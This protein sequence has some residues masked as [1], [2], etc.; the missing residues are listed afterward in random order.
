MAA[1]LSPLWISL[2]SVL[3][4]TAITFFLG[5]AAGRWL[6]GYHGKLRSFLDG[7]FVLPLV[8]P[9][10]V[11][12]LG[13]LLLFGVHGPMGKLLQLCG[14][15]VVFT[16]TATVIAAVVVSFPLMY[17]AARG[18]FEQVEANIEN[19]ART[20]GASEW[21]VFRSV[22]LPLAWPGVAAGLI[23]AFAR[24]LGEFGAT[25]MLAGYIPGR[26]GTIPMA[27][28]FAV[29]AG[30][31]N[32]A[33]ILVLIV[34]AVS[35]GSLAALAFWKGRAAESRFGIRGS[36]FEVEA[37]NCSSGHGC[38][39]NGAAS[40]SAAVREASEPT[41]WSSC[42]RNG[43]AS[44]CA[45]SNSGKG[46]R[47]GPE[48]EVAIRKSYP[49]FSLDVAFAVN[50]EILAIVGPSGSGKTMTLLCIA[51][52]IRPDA[53]YIRL[54]GR[55]LWDAATGLHLPPQQRKV[56][57]VF[58]NYALFPH[59][60]VSDNIALGIRH[61]PRPEIEER[62]YLLLDRMHIR[63][64]G[65]RYPG[66]LSGGQ[67]QRVAVA[68]ALAPEPEVLL[69][70]EPFAALDAQ[71][72]AR[73]EDELLALQDFYRGTVLFVTHDLAEGYK[74][75]SRIAVYESGRIL[76]C[77]S[78]Q[79]VIE[80][81]ASRAL[82]RLTGVR[83]LVSGHVDEIRGADA[84]VVAPVLGG[85]IRV[86]LKDGA[87]ASLS[88]GQQ[89]TVG[90]RPEYV[91]VAAGTPGGHPGRRA[92]PY[93]YPLTGTHPADG[94]R[95]PGVARGGGD[96]PPG[97]RPPDE[98]LLPGTVEQAVEGVAGIGYR[99]RLNGHAADGH[100]LEATISKADAPLIP[101]GKPCSVYLPPERLCLIRE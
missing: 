3:T 53:G 60:T 44:N 14:A 33:L 7:I 38:R 47:T 39:R 70:D 54:N 85:R 15:S 56:G 101:S 82:A 80:A 48:L 96:G 99:I 13:L 79:K 65:H 40:D 1:Y 93:G 75:S 59:L 83:N 37:D 49:E 90:I 19:A 51:G 98:N 72:R 55:A 78:K 94:A 32:Q 8:L 58:Q 35:F 66:Q 9:P 86:A 95:P 71:V 41:G 73:L 76:Q 43:A 23:L 74:L 89:V 62:V 22:T 20:L 42:R 31:M 63:G 52:L 30:D 84:W 68:R 6:A 97:E 18:A 91:R 16:W 88:V 25:L 5:I 36:G 27:I 57:F 87:S 11:V 34:L 21:R 81:P 24:A 100:Y 61:L 64:L 92:H 2:K 10:T 26:T 69:M 45:A 50:Q 29:E 67:Q 12:G 77:D 4:A 28:Y 46:G 17:M